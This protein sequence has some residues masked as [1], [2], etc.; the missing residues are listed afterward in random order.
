MIHALP[1]LWAEGLPTEVAYLTPPKTTAPNA[2]IP[3]II[4]AKV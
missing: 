2:R 4:R 3:E 1:S